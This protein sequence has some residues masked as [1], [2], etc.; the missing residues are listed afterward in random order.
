MEIVLYKDAFNL[1]KGCRM[2]TGNG[3]HEHITIEDLEKDSKVDIDE[4]EIEDLIH[5]YTVE[6]KIEECSECRRRAAV[7]VA[8][9][10]MF[11]VPIW[12]FVRRG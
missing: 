4:S 1:E 12:E 11:G 2:D 5:Y 6:T 8:T 9:E 10:K 7:A 3:V